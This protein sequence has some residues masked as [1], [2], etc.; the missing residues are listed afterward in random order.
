MFL[1]G[2]NVCLDRGRARASA[3][4]VPV[5][6]LYAPEAIGRERKG[7]AHSGRGPPCPG[8]RRWLRG[9]GL[10]RAGPAW[11]LT[12]GFCR[13]RSEQLCLLKGDR[14]ALP[15]RVSRAWPWRAVRGFLRAQR[16]RHGSRVSGRS[17]GATLSPTAQ[18]G[19]AVPTPRPAWV[20]RA[21]SAQLGVPGGRG[22]GRAL[23]PHGS[24]APEAPPPAYLRLHHAWPLVP[25]V[26]Q[27]GRDVDLLSACNRQTHRLLRQ[28]PG[29]RGQRCPRPPQAPG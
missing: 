3:P 14:S 24:S 1:K 9:R 16:G 7:P 27:G 10:G 15:G 28:A 19:A 21:A 11:P 4:A 20:T 6:V 5:T 23:T 13:L 17:E 8:H 18:P 25:Q 29:G 26:L 12:Q 22:D 2:W